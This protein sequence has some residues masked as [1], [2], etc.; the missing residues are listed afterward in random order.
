M[1][2]S[3]HKLEKSYEY[4][5]YKK[6]P[7]SVEEHDEAERGLIIYIDHPGMERRRPNLE[8]EGTNYQGS[9]HNR[10]ETRIE[11]EFWK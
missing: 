10:L 11:F 1:V 3:Q 4:E 2:P 8:E 9:A 7:D 6:F 5:K